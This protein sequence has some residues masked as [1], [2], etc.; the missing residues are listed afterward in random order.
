[1]NILDKYVLIYVAPP[2]IRTLFSAVVM[3]GRVTPDATVVLV[4][5]YS[6]A[7]SAGLYSYNY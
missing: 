7:P 5:N 1:M 6:Q 3:I 4:R 2:L